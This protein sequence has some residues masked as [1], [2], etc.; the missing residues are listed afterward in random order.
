MKEKTLMTIV[1]LIPYALVAIILFV[2]ALVGYK[3]AE[4]RLSDSGDE[5]IYFG[6]CLI[7][8]DKRYSLEN[9]FI[10]TIKSK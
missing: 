1:A 6:D 7:V 2:S 3:I 9:H 5:T 8:D 10:D 4:S